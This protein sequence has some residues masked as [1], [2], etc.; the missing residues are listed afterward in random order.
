[1]NYR[2]ESNVQLRTA[3]GYIEFPTTGASASLFVDSNQQY[4]GVIRNIIYTLTRKSDN[5][6]VVYNTMSDTVPSFSDQYIT[7]EKSNNVDGFKI[8]MDTVMPS[9]AQHYELEAVINYISGK[10][11]T[12]SANIVVQE[13][14][15]PI[16]QSTNQQ[17]Y[18]PINTAWTAQFGSSI[19]KNNLYKVD[20]LAIT[21]DIDFSTSTQLNNFVTSVNDYLFKYLENC[22]GIIMDGCTLLQITD[23]YIA[24]ENKNQFIF[25]NMSN[26]KRFYAQNC[27]SLTGTIDLSM[28]PEL[29]EVDTSGTAVNV[30]IPTGSKITKYE[31]GTPTTIS[32]NSPTVLSPSG[33][34]VDHSSN[35]DSLDLINIPNNNAYSMFNKIMTTA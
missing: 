15:S 30:I 29:L 17:L 14:G 4:T 2:L 11:Q 6:S 27:T 16:V 12:V 24:G 9:T 35:I 21:H 34:V 25:S 33:V 3:P 10:T 32:L 20:L 26:L 8:T 19:G 1:M 5:A 28:C 23:N 13:D 22:E 31:L 7:V 18:T